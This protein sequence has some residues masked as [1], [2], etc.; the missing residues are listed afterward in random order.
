[1]GGVFYNIFTIGVALYHAF[2]L[3]DTAGFRTIIFFAIY[4]GLMYI[5]VKLT[6]K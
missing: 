5:Y 6:Y 2:S 3:A 4:I 1:M